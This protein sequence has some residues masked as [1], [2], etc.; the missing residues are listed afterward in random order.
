MSELGEKVDRILELLSK[1]N[2]VTIEELKE[3]I[4]L[5]DISLLNFM[6]HGELIELK[7]EDVSIT[8]FGYEIIT[9]E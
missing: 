9:V 8:E 1:Q 7:N 5:E 2:T 6:H 3:K 4:S